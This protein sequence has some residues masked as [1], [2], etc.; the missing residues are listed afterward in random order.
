MRGHSTKG[1]A[2]QREGERMI[3]QKEYGTIVFALENYQLLLEKEGSIQ[4][5]NKV[6]DLINKVCRLEEAS[7]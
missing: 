1:R 2:R 5:R 4:A 6:T 7:K 3:T